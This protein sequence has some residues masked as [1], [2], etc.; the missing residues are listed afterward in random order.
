MKIRVTLFTYHKVC[1][2]RDFEDFMGLFYILA[3]CP[4]ERHSLVLNQGF[5]SEDSNE[6]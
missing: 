3:S 2:L 1:G 4:T 6:K 5:L